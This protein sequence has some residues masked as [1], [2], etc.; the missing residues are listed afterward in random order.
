M[1]FFAAAACICRAFSFV[2]V[3]KRRCQQTCSRENMLHTEKSAEFLKNTYCMHFSAVIGLF[4]LKSQQTCLQWKN[5]FQ[6]LVSSL[7]I[8]LIKF[9][10]TDRSFYN[11]YFCW[12]TDIFTFYKTRIPF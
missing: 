6:E 1:V 10:F 7:I 5:T 9:G 12:I 11:L 3:I 4:I 8:G 2:Y